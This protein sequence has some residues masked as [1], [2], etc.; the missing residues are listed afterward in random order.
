M[1]VV[2]KM[3]FECETCGEETGFCIN[4]TPYCSEHMLDGIGVQARLAAS[5]NG[6]GSDEIKAMGAWAQ[7][8]LA[9]L[10]GIRRSDE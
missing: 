10:L 1:A 8:E 6:A 2:M 9:A 3:T 7:D 4:G 5:L